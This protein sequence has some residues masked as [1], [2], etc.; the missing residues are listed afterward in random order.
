MSCVVALDVSMGKSYVVS[1][2]K[3]TCVEEKEIFHN[4][5]G[6]SKLRKMIEECPVPPQVVFEATGVYSKPIEKFLQDE[7]IAYSCL[8]PMEA[9]RQLNMEGLRIHK[10]DRS[11]AHRLA[12]THSLFQR[13][14]TIE[15][16]FVYK[17]A[18]NL[19]R[20]YHEVEGAIKRDRMAL[21]T[22]LH[23][24]FPELESL[25]VNRISKLSLNLVELFPHPALL[26]GFSRTRVKN[27]LLKN[28]DKKI[29]QKKALKKAEELLELTHNSYPAVSK[30]SVIVK[31]VQ[32][33]SRRLMELLLQKEQLQ[34]ELI[35]IVQS[36]PEFAILTSL[37]GIGE[38]TAALLIGELGDIRR[39]ATNRKLNAYVGIDIRRYQSGKYQGIDRINKRGNGKARMILFFTIKNMVRQQRAAPNHLVDYYYKLKKGPHPKK[40]KVATVA[41]INKLIK[42]IHFL[43]LN[44]QQYDY[45]KAPKAK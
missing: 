19:A 1:Y 41:C 4:K 13:P 42:T 11:D 26:N 5:Q 7:S 2:D 34:K 6:F 27:I 10:T 24:S 20:F 23:Q 45:T 16:S 37:P 38:P 9:S 12:Q 44:N 32:Y 3:T 31:K 21:H 35:Q 39:F 33:Y 8:N 17:E 22:A 28:T 29:S 36:L 15:S 14:R 30:D 43:I 40:D 25:F 18:R